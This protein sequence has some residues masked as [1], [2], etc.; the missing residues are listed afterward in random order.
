MSILTI[1]AL[2]IFGSIVFII[3]GIPVPYALGAC[4]VIG[5][6][7]GVGTPALAKLGLTAFT[8]FYSVN[9]TP[10]PL[11][12]LMAYLICETEIGTDI[13]TAANAWLSRIPGGLIVTSIWAEAAMA[14]TMGA[15]G[16][17]MLTVGNVALPQMERL[18]YNR[19]ISVGALLAGGVLG[20]LIP[21]SIPF[22]IYAN[23]AQQSITQLFIA[24]VMPGILLAIMLSGYTMIAC[25]RRPDL[26]PRLAR[27]SW[28]DRIFSL[29][30]I[31]P[32]V[33]LMFGILG[34]IY[35]GVVTATEAGAIGVIIILIIAVVFYRFR[36]ANLKRAMMDSAILTGMIGLMIPGSMLLSYLIGS[37]GMLKILSDFA[38]SSWLSPWMVIISINILLLFLGCIMDG[39]A[40]LL[41]CV[42]LFIPI[43][44]ALG[45]NPVWFGVLMC[46]NLEIGL[47][48]PPIAMN[49]YLTKSV[50]NIPI[51][52][53]IRGVFPYLIV[54]II[55]LGILIAFPQISL[56]LP[57]M[58]KAG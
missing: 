1:T 15:S 40:I 11:F 49:L 38:T 36:L 37:S 30:K 2:C 22:I 18:G 54:L 41:I 25:L 48:T 44:E 26:A 3:I 28:K 14:A 39:L 43:I 46:V 23:L 34:G 53:I 35:L 9:W 5:I 33:V 29:R 51:S 7:F 12:I 4:A 47:I 6:L 55:F 52:E 8:S 24:G 58:M 50:F 45:F 13:F 57:G 20:P 42:P 21:P 10:L 31:W 19:R 16:T 56:W 27:I 32:V 17:T